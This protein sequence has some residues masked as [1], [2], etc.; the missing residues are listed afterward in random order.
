VNDKT[1]PAPAMRA[2]I[3]RWLIEKVAPVYDAVKADPSRT[4]PAKQ[5]RANLRAHHAARRKLRRQ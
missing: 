2:A 3:E 1:M 4:I 5:V